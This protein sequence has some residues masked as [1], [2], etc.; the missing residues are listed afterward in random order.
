MPKLWPK[1]IRDPVHGIVPFED[2]ESDK[3]LLDLINTPEFQRLRRIKQLGMSEFVFPGANHSRF[4]HC[5]GVMHIARLMLDRTVRLLG[6]RVSRD[7]RDAVLVA[8]LLHDAGHG[9]FSHAF[10]KVTSQSHEART[11]E[12]VQDKSTS[13]S[14]RLRKY[15]TE[16]PDRLAVFFDED[17]D[18]EKKKQAAI[19]EFLTQ[20]VSSQLDA[21]RFDY[22]LRDSHATGTDY[23]R[24][25]LDWLLLQLLVDEKRRRFC[26][27]HKSI[28]AAEA[29]VFARFHMYRSVYFHKT[30]RA[31]EVM[32]RLLFKRFK[33]LLHGESRRA[34]KLAIVPG[35]PEAVVDA[36][37]GKL[38]LDRYL[39]L[40]DTAAC[41]FFKACSDS[42]DKVLSSL[43]YGLTF[44]RLH[45][46]IDATG[47][48]PAALGNF[49]SKAQDV[50][51]RAK[52]NPD[53]H[54]VDDTAADTPY[55]P[56]DPDAAKPASQIYVCTG[57][58]EITEI[59]TQAQSLRELQKKYALL[60]Y[61]FP[62][63][64]RDKI[65]KI[66]R[67]TIAKEV[68]Q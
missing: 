68:Q 58:G 9:P 49:A 27:S 42:K 1:V 18:V 45:K 60:R 41:E 14:K 66:A 47:A 51:R 12:I 40:D 36:F 6:K 55:K 46:G 24:F 53:Y 4:A 56:Y 11:L 15:N 31:A 43:G 64:M 17:I 28:S 19:P 32:V 16:L 67:E 39:A 5:I 65:E 34:K 62:D 61:Y 35:A 26:L 29:Y 3:L 10:E 50:I 57:K 22:L 37:A 23:G 48:D 7:Q 25:D 63:G 38:S 30:V 21:D 13:I 52:L 8:A 2:S 54:F 59:S 20:I 44:R 33:E